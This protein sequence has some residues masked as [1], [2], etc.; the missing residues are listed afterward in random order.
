[1]TRRAAAV[2]IGVGI[3]ATGSRASALAGTHPIV[4]SSWDSR[5]SNVALEYRHGFM[6]GGGFNDVA[7]NA[8]FTSTSGRLSAQFGLHYV[9]FTAKA[10]DPTAH[11][12][13]AT[14]TAL[15]VLPLTSRFDNGLPK[16]GLAFALGSAPTTYVSGSLNYVTIP[17]VL[18]VGVPLS[19]AKVIT[20]TPWFELSPSVNLDTEIKPYQ[21]KASDLAGNVGPD[22]SITL[23]NGDVEKI[24]T[25]SVKFKT[26]VNAG[27]RAGIDLALHLSDAVD[28]AANV[29]LSSA[30][31]AFSGP[32]VTYVGG[33][34]VWRWD[35]IVPAVLPAD[36]RL[37][38]ENCGDIE[39]RF[40][41]CPNSRRWKRPE[42]TAPA[43]NAP[44][45]APVPA[46]RP[47]VPTP[48]AAPPAPARAA[49]PSATTAPP[50]PAPAPA[51]G[52]NPVGTTSFPP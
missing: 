2:A 28:F 42:D 10:A 22:G 18:A 29:A 14:A 7:Y 5:A 20:F 48:S 34:V 41:M 27:A 37:L 30:G 50:P 39:D 38:H 15:I 6:K 44:S 36:K 9:N 17:V 12:L 25:D 49:P 35:D 40:R 32:T 16:A 43:P 13:A 23:D 19:P 24:V 33:G 52:T 4:V 47:A 1:M 11:G 46:P 26:S 21:L 45:A 8:D 31:S 3:L 51:P